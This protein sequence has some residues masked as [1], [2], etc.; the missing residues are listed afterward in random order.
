M[1]DGRVTRSNS[2]Q[3][4][5][6]FMENCSKNFEKLDKRLGNIDIKN[7]KIE[8]DISKMKDEIIK[9]LVDSNLKLQNQVKKLEKQVE[10]LEK[11]G[12]KITI[13]IESTNQ[14]GRRNNVEIAGIPNEINDDDLE[15]KVCEIFES[16]DAEI[17]SRDIEA[18]HRLPPKKNNPIKKTI[19]RFMNRKNVEKILKNKKNLDLSL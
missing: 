11:N 3:V 16:V 9:H 1:T 19:V 6:D 17:E 4:T 14:Y 7:S 15:K 8:T 5:T 10:I 12:K 13:N 2:L 18:C